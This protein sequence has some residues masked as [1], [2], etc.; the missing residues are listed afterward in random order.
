[1]IFRAFLAA[2]SGL[3][4]AACNT[5]V[6]TRE[7]S[8]P[9]GPP[10]ARDHAPITVSHDGPGADWRARADAELAERLNRPRREGRAKNVILFVADGLNVPTITAA[11]ILDGQLRG[12]TGEENYLPFE[13]WGHSALIKTYNENAQTPDSAGT[14]T[15]LLSGVKSHI[16]AI[17]VYARQTLEACGPDADVPM[18]TLEA[19]ELR[20]MATGIVS[21]ARI[22]HATPAAAYAHAP[23]RDWEVD[24]VLP[25]DAVAAGCTDIAAQLVGT[26]DGRHGDGPELVLG[27]GRGAFLT[28]DQGGQRQDGRDLTAEWEAAGG[29]FVEN[30]AEFRA[31]DVDGP[32]ALGLFARSHLSYEHDRDE[33]EEPSVAEM[34][35]FA[36]NRLS[37]DED[38]YF[39]LV[40]AGRVDHAHHGTNA[41]RALTDALAFA[42]AVETAADMTDP[43]ETLILVTADHGHVFS[44][45]GYAR[46]GNPILGLV[47]PPA[48][49]LS[50]APTPPSPARDGRPYTALGYY[51][52][53]HQ[54]P[55]D[56]ALT[57]EDV[58][59]PNYRQE[60]AVPMGSETHSAEDV[61][62]F[63]RGPWAHLV[64]GTMEQNTL[65]RIMTFAL[66][67]DGN[68][69][70]RE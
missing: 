22:T 42:R 15:A 52:G 55:A 13:T 45:A 35:E 9:Q 63:A 29:V 53:P 69:A 39:L 68:T 61:A 5:M 46:R 3:S 1:M 21:T 66:G 47:H 34:T 38:G 48:P 70:P 10:P 6:D 14:A 54:R 11:R 64:D 37:A 12:E 20:G 7:T 25:E 58:L 4:L 62:A 28:A 8:A 2:A 33:A 36:I 50:D 40:E 59:D 43:D 57:Q 30:A 44:I 51:N 32:R 56:G 41:H 65:N 60:S 18:S 24:A 16:G 49:D 31:L 23:S 26:L 19:A 17:G 27:G 67:W